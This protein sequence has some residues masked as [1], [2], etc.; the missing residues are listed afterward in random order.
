MEYIAKFKD[1][2]GAWTSAKIQVLTV[3]AP[4]KVRGRVTGSNWA[5]DFTVPTL[6]GNPIRTLY[7][8]KKTDAAQWIASL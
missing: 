3:G 1:S 2:W 8:S 5:V 6:F 4:R 7:F